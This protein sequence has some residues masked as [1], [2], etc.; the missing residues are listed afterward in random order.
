MEHILEFN[1]F[2]NESQGGNKLQK[3][4]K[5]WKPK[6]GTFAEQVFKVLLRIAD[7]EQ[8][9]DDETD[10]IKMAAVAGSKDPKKVEAAVDE[11]LRTENSYQDYEEDSDDYELM[12]DAQEEWDDAYY[13]AV[14][15]IAAIKD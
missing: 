14:S 11:L 10:A 3:K 8:I 6:K 9:D 12:D 4:Y 13:Y 5:N 2:L 1:D 15:L 7:G